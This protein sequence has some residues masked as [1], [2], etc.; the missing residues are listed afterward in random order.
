MFY[1]L[2]VSGGNGGGEG[3][4]CCPRREWNGWAEA[5]TLSGSLACES[6]VNLAGLEVQGGS[7]VY[8]KD[9][10]INNIKPTL[11]LCSWAFL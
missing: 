4:N 10:Y 1:F 7:R 6:T 3:R 5:V 11:K 9:Q 2:H 8:N